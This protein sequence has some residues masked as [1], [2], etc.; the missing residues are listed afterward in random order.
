MLYQMLPLCYYRNFAF[1]E[2]LKIFRFETSKDPVQ[3]Q[4]AFPQIV[5][6][7]PQRLATNEEV[8]YAPWCSI[9]YKTRKQLKVN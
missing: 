2:K 1:H 3:W 4:I 6:S 7:L 8:G 5:S 9:H